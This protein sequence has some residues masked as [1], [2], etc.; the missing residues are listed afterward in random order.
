M[1]KQIIF[2]L[3]K[4]LIDEYKILCIKNNITMTQDLINYIK[5]KIE[6]SQK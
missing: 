6:Q 5:Q 2:K 4:S 1:Q 3:D